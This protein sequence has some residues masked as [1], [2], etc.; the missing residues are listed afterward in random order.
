MPP[1]DRCS[2]HGPLCPRARPYAV[3]CTVQP[4]ALLTAARRRPAVPILSRRPVR[5]WLAR[6]RRRCRHGS[7]KPVSARTSSAQASLVTAARA[8]TSRE[9]PR[10]PPIVKAA[11][12][13][14]FS[15]PPEPTGLIAI[16]MR[17]CSSW[18]VAPSSAAG[19]VANAYLIVVC[20]PG[21]RVWLGDGDIARQ[22]RA[23]RV[24]RHR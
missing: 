19:I 18:G 24:A 5:C 22:V 13:C 11:S 3:L 7:N 14:R 15:S 12:P 17:R 21:A 1:A 23:P 4:P 6:R 2:E 9:K 10:P 20:P 8:S 16:L